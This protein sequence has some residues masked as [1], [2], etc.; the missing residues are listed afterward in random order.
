VR[1]RGHANTIWAADAL[2][3][4][5]EAF[6]DAEGQGVALGVADHIVRS[7]QV[8]DGPR[9]RAD[10]ADGFFSPC[11]LWLLLAL[12]GRYSPAELTGS[13]ESVRHTTL[14]RPEQ[15]RTAHSAGLNFSRAWG[16]HAAWVLTGDI[17]H[18]DNFVR[19][20]TGHMNLPG[21][22]R[23]HYEA[24]GHWVAQFGAF[25]IALTGADG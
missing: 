10:L 17:Q 19:L 8:L 4:W 25:A 23:D 1:V 2:L 24:Y 14:L 6:D 12:H 22:W 20:V 11:H 16:C 21:Y 9:V 3:C 15:L 7:R 13:I 5:S 18:R